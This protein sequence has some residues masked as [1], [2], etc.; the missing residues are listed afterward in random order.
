[1]FGNVESIAHNNHVRS[2][3]INAP[4]SKVKSI[5]EA[6]YKLVKTMYDGVNLVTYKQKDGDI[7]TFNNQRILHGRAAYKAT[8]MRHLSGCYF[9]WDEAYSAIRVYRNK[10]GLEN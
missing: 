4:A 5:Y 7:V 1:M 8:T 9:D 10:L 6:Y 2:S 3:F